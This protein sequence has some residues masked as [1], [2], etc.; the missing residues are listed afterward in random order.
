MMPEQVH[1]NE[2]NVTVRFDKSP[3]MALM[4]KLQ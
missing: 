4:D 2:Q 3:E 1:G